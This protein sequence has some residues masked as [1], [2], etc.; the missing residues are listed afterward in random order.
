MERKELLQTKEYWVTSLQIAIYN[1]AMK[2]MADH[3]MNRTQLAQHL[4]VTKGY[5]TQLLNGE[6]DHR[7][8]KLVELALAFG[9]VPEFNF[10]AIAE[11]VAQDELDIKL[12]ETYSNTNYSLSP[13]KILG[14]NNGWET[15]NQ[16]PV[17]A[18]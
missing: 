14:S 11:Y 15:E 5:V 12:K 6:Y 3:A 8:S 10:K 2:Y 17:G 18:A 7:I 9:Y 16:K 13:H 4:G 1:C